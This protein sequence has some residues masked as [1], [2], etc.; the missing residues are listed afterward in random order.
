[1]RKEP[2]DSNDFSMRI[3]VLLNKKDSV[4]HIHSLAVLVGEWLLQD[5]YL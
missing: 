1:M 3:Y 4:T 5:T 2:M